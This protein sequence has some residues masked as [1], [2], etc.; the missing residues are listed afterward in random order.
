MQAWRSVIIVLVNYL[1][2]FANEFDLIIYPPHTT[3]THF[4]CDDELK[5]TEELISYA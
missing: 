3:G 1:F 5:K 2:D 4:F